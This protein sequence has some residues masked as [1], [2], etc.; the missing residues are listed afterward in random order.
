MGNEAHV[1]ELPID[2]PMLFAGFLTDCPLQ[3]VEHDQE[4]SVTART[5]WP[6]DQ[7]V[8]LADDG[9]FAANGADDD[10]AEAE[11]GHAVFAKAEAVGSGQEGIRSMGN[12]LELS[13]GSTSSQV[14][15]RST[16]RIPRIELRCVGP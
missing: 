11:T 13:E 5:E 15:G 4:P 7:G 6:G 2:P 12:G 9:A 14:G 3:R 16:I 10:L 1:A 8:G